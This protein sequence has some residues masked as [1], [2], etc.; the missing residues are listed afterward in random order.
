MLLPC[1]LFMLISINVK[2]IMFY[3][4]F[5][6]MLTALLESTSL[7][8]W[9]Y[10]LE[11]SL[12]LQPS[13][14]GTSCI[15]WGKWLSWPLVCSSTLDLYWL[16]CAGHQTTMMFL[17]SMWLLAV[18]ACVM[19]SGPHKLTVSTT[20]WFISVSKRSS[21][22]TIALLWTTNTMFII[23]HGRKEQKL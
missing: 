11:L 23:I 10:V 7:V 19:Q 14:L 13:P 3:D 20:W 5:S 22:Y 21:K 6:L 18:L 15:T 2:R 1:F 12:Q 16:C 9:W 8:M 4:C 17:Y